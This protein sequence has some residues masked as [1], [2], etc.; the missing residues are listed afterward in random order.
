MSYKNHDSF[1]AQGIRWICYL[2]HR[3]KFIFWLLTEDI[4]KSRAGGGVDQQSQEHNTR[5]MDQD[6]QVKIQITQNLVSGLK[7][8]SL[9]YMNQKLQVQHNY[10]TTFQ[11]V[12]P[13]VTLHHTCS[14]L[15]VYSP[16]CRQSQSQS[17][18]D[19][20]PVGPEPAPQPPSDRPRSSPYPPA[21]ID[22]T[23]CVV[24]SDWRWRLLGLYRT[25]TEYS[26][27]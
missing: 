13:R 18:R 14:E 3:K 24:E 2:V 12:R 22:R 19:G 10:Q 7:Y 6:L 21:R 9:W 4:E 15:T 1:S 25:N 17:H 16:G 27:T 5:Y 23:R 20:P 11:Y 26:K 8:H